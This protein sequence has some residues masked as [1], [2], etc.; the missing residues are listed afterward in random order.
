MTFLSSAFEGIWLFSP[1]RSTMSTP[2]P[3]SWV[4]RIKFSA[5]FI[6]LHEILHGVNGTEYTI[7]LQARFDG[8]DYPVNGSA[9]VDSI[10]YTPV[11]QFAVRGTGKKNGEICLTEVV[12]VDPQMKTLTQNYQ[13]LI[14]GQTVAYGVA[15]FELRATASLAGGSVSS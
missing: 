6:Q 2:T 14:A 9:T 4:Q 3:V 5:D 1:E 11:D 12:T 8:A 15:V 10:A 7:E 13:Y